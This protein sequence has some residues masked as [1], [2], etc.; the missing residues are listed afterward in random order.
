ML[1]E[2]AASTCTTQQARGP[3]GNP[4][5]ATEDR[6]PYGPAFSKLRKSVNSL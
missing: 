4:T 1:L 5:G 2:A 3:R 6:P